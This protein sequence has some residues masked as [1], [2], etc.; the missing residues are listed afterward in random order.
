MDKETLSNYGWIVVCV[1]VLA[2]LLAL[3]SPFGSF[4]ATAIK[5][6]TQGLFDVN[7][8]ALD[9]AGIVLPDQEF[10]TVAYHIIEGAGQEITPKTNA[11]FCSDAG[12]DKFVG[13]KIDGNTIDPSNYTVSGELTTIELNKEYIDI[14]SEAE[15]ELI[16]ESEDGSASCMFTMRR[17]QFDALFA[18]DGTVLKTWEELV[19]EGKVTVEG[20]ALVGINIT[21]AYRLLVPGTIKTFSVINRDGAADKLGFKVLEFEEG[22]E[23]VDCYIAE[24]HKDGIEKIIL[25]SSIKRFD[26]TK[27]YQSSYDYMG[28]NFVNCSVVI[29]FKG[30]D[31]DF[32]VFNLWDDWHA[33]SELPEC[34]YQCI[35]TNETVYCCGDETCYLNVGPLRFS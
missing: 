24:C 14:L 9:I 5:S 6:T 26:P 16:I 29:S 25:P 32:T 15:H 7:Q 17:P 20:D 13:V 4:V 1:M 21:G 35:L 12:F 18:E 10:D 30:T 11:K 33:F 19:A 3:A 22:L 23:L 28:G 27:H 2:V 8:N 31:Y 34:Y